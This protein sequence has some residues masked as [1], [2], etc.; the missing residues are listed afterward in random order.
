M[1]LDEALKALEPAATASTPKHDDSFVGICRFSLLPHE[2]FEMQGADGFVLPQAANVS[3]I[4]V[5]Q[6]WRPADEDDGEEWP[7][8]VGVYVGEAAS[9]AARFKQYRL[10][11]AHNKRNGGVNDLKE[12]RT[13]GKRHAL[14][15]ER[16]VAWWMQQWLKSSEDRTVTLN[17]VVQAES[18]RSDKDDWSDLPL[19]S[20][21]PRRYVESVV[22]ATIGQPL[23]SPDSLLNDN[24]VYLSDLGINRTPPEDEVKEL[25]AAATGT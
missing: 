14:K 4:Y 25:F 17:V 15:H 1:D 2:T 13:D 16:G 8:R 23:G 24:N 20:K 12:K 22:I 11:G 18:R 9:L 21:L 19:F 7:Q 3:G 5:F 6:R 10:A